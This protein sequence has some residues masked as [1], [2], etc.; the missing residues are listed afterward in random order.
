[1]PTARR[2]VAMLDGIH[3][4]TRLRTFALMRSRAAGSST[5]RE[6]F[7][8]DG[9]KLIIESNSMTLLNAVLRSL[10]LVD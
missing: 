2:H 10:D 6:R 9:R 8:I 4:C 5:E 1:M 3:R 7:P